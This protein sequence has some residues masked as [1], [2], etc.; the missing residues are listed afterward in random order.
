[1]GLLK[2][3]NFPKSLIKAMPVWMFSP[4]HC[5]GRASL[6]AE[7]A[8]TRVRQCIRLPRPPTQHASV[9]VQWK[10]T[11]ITGGLPILLQGQHLSAYYSKC[12]WEYSNRSLPGCTFHGWFGSHGVRPPQPTH[13]PGH[14]PTCSP[15]CSICPSYADKRAPILGLVFVLHK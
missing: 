3:L 12:V 4:S 5:L 10:V 11:K 15:V 6:W 13:R 8:G 1:M 2:A 14:L 9:Y 7:R